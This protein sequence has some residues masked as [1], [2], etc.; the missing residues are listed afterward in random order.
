MFVTVSGAST[1]RHIHTVFQNE[2]RNKLYLELQCVANNS[3]LQLIDGPSNK[4]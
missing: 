3:T 2:L 4:L 1:A